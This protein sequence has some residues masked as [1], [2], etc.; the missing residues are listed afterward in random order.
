MVTSSQKALI[1][2]L[3][4]HIKGE[5]TTNSSCF[6]TCFFF[7][8]FHDVSY[9]VMFCIM[10]FSITHLFYNNNTQFLHT[11]FFCVFF[12]IFKLLL[13]I[14]NKWNPFQI[15]FLS[16]DD[17]WPI[18]IMMM[19]FFRNQK[20]FHRIYF[21]LVQKPPPPSGNLIDSLHFRWYF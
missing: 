17:Q 19:I 3:E 12:C 21:W 5:N 20:Y 9:N 18:M 8:L 2:L 7:T 6:I 14:I 10:S 15:R 13:L 11:T 1:Y 16:K 4:N